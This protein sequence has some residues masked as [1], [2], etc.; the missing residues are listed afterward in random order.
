MTLRHYTG[1]TKNGSIESEPIQ[2]ANILCLQEVDE[3]M[4]RSGNRRIAYEI[5]ERL[6]MHVVV[7]SKTCWEF[8]KGIGEER[9][10]PSE[11][12]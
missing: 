3:G 5:G 4:A 9:V 2:S 11:K 1:P 10:A 7:W 8:T 12:E 6:G